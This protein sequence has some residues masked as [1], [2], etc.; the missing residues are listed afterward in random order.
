M[1]KKE[2]TAVPRLPGKS[3]RIAIIG[4]T[5]S[6]KTQ[7]AVWHLSMQSID[8][9]PWIVLDFKTDKLINSIAKATDIDYT[10]VPKKPGIYVLHPLPNEEEELNEYIYKLWAQEGVGIYTD[11]GYMVGK[12]KAFNACL[13]Q[14]RSKQIP[15]ITLSQRPLWL[16]RF[17]FSEANFFQIFHLND[18]E[19]QKTVGRFIPAPIDKRLPEYYSRYYDVDKD[20]LYKFSPVPSAD[21]ILAALDAKLPSPKRTL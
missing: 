19:D 7:A 20:A 2:K 21:E 1:T 16:S 13:T 6:G 8:T 9:M 4:R 3:D 15:M 12:S 11:E 18:K 10:F 5:G 17:V 14:G